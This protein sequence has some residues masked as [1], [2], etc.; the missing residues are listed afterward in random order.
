MSDTQVRAT[1][2]IL[3]ISISL[4]SV[5]CSRSRNTAIVKDI[6]Q[7][8]ASDPE[9][10][11]SRISVEAK[12]GKVVLTGQIKTPAAQLKLEQIASQEPGISSV[13]D[14]TVVLQPDNV[15]SQITPA[16]LPGAPP[17]SASQAPES[18][19]VTVMAETS[20]GP[21]PEKPRPPQPLVVPSGTVLTIRTGSA[22]SS[23]T[24]QAG[25]SFLGS[26]AKPVSIKGQM[27]I[28]AGSAVTGTVV[29]A[30]P[31]GKL[32]GEAVLNLALNTVTVRGQSYSIQT[33]VLQNTARG[34]G[35][36]TAA[37]TGGGAAGG[38]LIGGIAGGGKGAGIGAL[39]GGAAGFVGGAVTGNQQIEIPAESAVSFYLSAPLIIRPSR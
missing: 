31:K 25:Q 27:V 35:K 22:L 19:P 11:D 39:V 32:K 12:A 37:T 24:S 34:K 4:F 7:K 33:N 9:T 13:E 38:A 5:S 1:S 6:Q 18:P 30:K 8:V 29:D 36:R 26:L 2:V 28:P 3:L 21:P 16:A 15:S 20:P 23:G 14:R 17:T 10:R